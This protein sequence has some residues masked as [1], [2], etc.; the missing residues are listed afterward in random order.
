VLRETTTR[1]RETSLATTAL[2]RSAGALAATTGLRVMVVD[3]GARGA[4]RARAEPDEAVLSSIRARGGLAGLATVPGAAA[5]VARLTPDGVDEADVA[6]LLQTLRTRPATLPQ[7]AEELALAQ[8]AA[9]LQLTSLLEDDP[10]GP[11]DLLVGCG[12][13]IASA[14]HTAQAMRI[15]LDGVRPLGVTQVAIDAAAVLGPLGSLPDGEIREGMA[16]LGDDLVA[17]LGTAVV[18]RGG[19]A[20]RP[21]MRVTVHRAGW[22][23]SSPIEVRV[24]QL[25]VVPLARGLEAELTIELSDGVTLG[26]PR[27]SPRIHATATGGAVGLVLDARGIPIALPRRADDRRAVLAGWRDA[28]QREPGRTLEGLS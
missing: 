25:M 2:T 23:A 10:P 20:G 18:T 4:L 22:P 28:L 19:D 8:T 6:D 12:S 14:P 24:G 21:A 11:M 13:T 7:S 15:L 3:V 9:R 16:L 1:D 26:A 5:R 27:R 17:P